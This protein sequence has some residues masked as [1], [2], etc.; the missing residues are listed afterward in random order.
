M[1]NVKYDLVKC[2]A[3]RRTIAKRKAVHSHNT[4]K[5]CLVRFY[6]LTIF[7]QHL[8]VPD[9]GKL[10]K[11]NYIHDLKVWKFINVTKCSNWNNMKAKIKI[12]VDMQSLFPPD[13]NYTRTNILCRRDVLLNEDRLDYKSER[14][15]PWCERTVYTDLGFS[16]K[17]YFTKWEPNPI[18]VLG[19]TFL[20]HFMRSGARSP[21][22]HC[23]Q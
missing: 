16:R 22:V 15:G 3:E 2:I 18:L 23:R 13:N 11:M 10:L 9:A 7:R 4:S 21:A 5:H 1:L 19:Q 20:A 6:K 14:M 17:L 8:N 12:D